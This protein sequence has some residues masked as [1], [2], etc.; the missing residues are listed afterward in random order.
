MKK[1]SLLAAFFCLFSAIAISAQN[2]TA[3]NFAGIWQL[4]RAKSKLPERMRI[5]SGALTVTQT[6]KTLTVATD[7]KRAPRPPQSDETGGMRPDGNRGALRGESGGNR[8]MAGGGNGTITYNLDGK[9]QTLE[10]ETYNAMPPNGEQPKTGSMT[11]QA[12]FESGNK[13]KLISS[14]SFET[15]NGSMSVKTTET[16]ELIDGGSALKVTRETETPRGSQ[17]SEMYFTKKTTISVEGETMSNNAPASGAVPTYQAPATDGASASTVRMINGG[18][19]NGKAIKMPQPAYPPAAKAVK[20]SGT[21]SV[22]VILDEQG[23]VV[24][25]TA[26]SGHPLLRAAAEE[27]ARAAEFSPTRLSGEPVKVKGVVV[28]NFIL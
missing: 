2:K 24:S 1:L 25:A 7:F 16:W 14:R 21:V 27:A 17:S 20:A 10:V 13:L 11:L 12:K 4:D 22:E 8:G 28:Y 5:E 19:I 26:V 6:D 18:V 9:E 15:P 3:T 23:K